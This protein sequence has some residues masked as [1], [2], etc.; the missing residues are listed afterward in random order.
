MSEWRLNPRAARCDI[1]EQDMQW[2]RIESN[3]AHYRGIVK[4][5]WSRLDDMGLDS[6][7]G[8]RARLAT[9]L[10]EEYGINEGESDEQIAAWQDSQD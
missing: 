9:L 1:E 7:K 5:R 6:I 2:D 4:Q 3:W 10:Q 8:K